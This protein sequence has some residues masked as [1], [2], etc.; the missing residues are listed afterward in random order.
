MATRALTEF[1]TRV[2]SLETEGTLRTAALTSSRLFLSVESQHF[3]ARPT[4]QTGFPQTPI[5]VVE[6]S[7]SRERKE[8]A[9]RAAKPRE[10]PHELL[11]HR[12]R[13]FLCKSRLHLATVITRIRW[14]YG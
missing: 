1:F 2:Y 6:S 9:A 10:L 14:F 11:T 13:W 3:L 12:V 8:E 4:S 5:A 7:L